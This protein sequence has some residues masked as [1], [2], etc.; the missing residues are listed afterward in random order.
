MKKTSAARFA[1]LFRQAE[2]QIDALRKRQ[3][4]LLDRFLKEHC[5]VMIND[6]LRVRSES[7]RITYLKI[8]EIGGAIDGSRRGPRWSVQGRAVTSMGCLTMRRSYAV[9]HERDFNREMIVSRPGP[10]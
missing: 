7:G 6:I 10:L 5:P 1:M 2:T 9:V 4:A 3:N 8:F